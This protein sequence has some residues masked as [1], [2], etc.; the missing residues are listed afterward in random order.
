MGKKA[1]RV[2]VGLTRSKEKELE[3][4][5]LQAIE[6]YARTIGFH[7]LNTVDL[8]KFHKYGTLVGEV[9]ADC[10]ES[11][12]S[13]PDVDFVEEVGRKFATSDAE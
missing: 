3:A 1:V 5:G 8:G 6:E 4:G 11:L 7:A 13:T 9:N 12:R 10:I 2:S